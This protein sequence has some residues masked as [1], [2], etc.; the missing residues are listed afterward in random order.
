MDIK[1]YVVTDIPRR[2]FLN[3]SF[4]GGVAL[5]A[6]PSLI[7]QLLSCKG[8]EKA[9]VTAASRTPTSSPSSLS[10]SPGISPQ[11]SKGT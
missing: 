2:K 3:L 10:S 11:S 9:A 1:K 7:M 4:K 8:A 5:A 6:T